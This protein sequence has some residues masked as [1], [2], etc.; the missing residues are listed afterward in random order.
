[1]QYL[2]SNSKQTKKIGFILGETILNSSP[3]KKNAF[4]IALKGNLGSGK[5][6]FIQGL[7][8]GLKIKSNFN[9]PTFIILKKY[10]I[11]QNKNFDFFYHLDLYRIK[12]IKELKNLDIFNL[13][14]NKKNIIAIEW[15]EKIKKFLPQNI[16]WFNFLYG[17][18]ENERIIK[19]LK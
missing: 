14:K 2:T 3:F 4:I 19:I 1:M 10:K 16:L 6:T 18:K 13:L 9:S 11:K 8:K 17:K 7:A 5:T 12:K 15:P